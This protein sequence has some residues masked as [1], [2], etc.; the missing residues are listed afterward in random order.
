MKFIDIS[1]KN[2]RCFNDVKI[3]LSTK[4]DD[5]N[6][7]LILAPNGG[8]KTET[9]FSFWW[10]LYGFD[11]RTLK[12]K[13]DAP[14]SL[15]QYK[16]TKLLQSP[17][18]YD[19]TVAVTLRF[20][21]GDYGYALKKEEVFTKKGNGI[22]SKTRVGLMMKDRKK[23]QTLPLITDEDRIYRILT[24]IIPKRILHGIVFDGERMKQL[25]TVDDDAKEAIQGII[26]DITNEE[27]FEMCKTELD[28]L[29]RDNNKE[30][31]KLSSSNRSSNI[32]TIVADIEA[33]DQAIRF[34]QVDM[35]AKIKEK[36]KIEARLLEITAELKK[37]ETAREIEQK[38]D[39]LREKLAY[40]NKHFD[41]YITSFFL[42]L[43]DGY[44]LIADPMFSSVEN[45]LQKKDIPEELT[46]QAVRNILKRDKCICGHDLGEHE[47]ELLTELIKSLPPDNVSSTLLEMT[48]QARNT[49]DDVKRRLSKS[50]KD[51]ETQEREI[52]EIKQVLS[53]ISSQLVGEGFS[54]KAKELENE[55][56]DLRV[57]LR[58]LERQIARDKSTIETKKVEMDSLRKEKASSSKNDSTLQY[59]D[60][61]DQIITKFEKA[62][63]EIDR[64]N[65][66]NALLNINDKLD[67]A[68]S[69]ISE[70]YERGRRIYIVQFDAR[71]KYRL[72]SY[73]AKNLDELYLTN[74]DFIKTLT[75][76]CKNEAEIR[77]ALILKICEPNSTGQSK[78][79]TLAFAK[80]ILDYSNE[81]R[82]KESVE[83]TKNYPFLIDSPFTELSGGNLS[84]SA[85]FIHTFSKQI[86]LLISEKSYD[87]VK[88][89][90]AK[91][92]C[93]I[94]K[95][96]KDPSGRYSF[97]EEGGN[98]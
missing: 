92:V 36:N 35:E 64:L 79:N 63:E 71:N 88:D 50:F 25:S 15:N 60:Q 78:I 72:V 6:I 37:D 90:V 16:Y 2:Y 85:E 95:I 48:R 39:Q 51:I 66:V 80:A 8:G 31:K 10:V 7:N 77:E 68:Y 82:D 3:T 52:G 49:S 62:L 21:D 24:K 44:L 67:R 13:K 45:S 81:E 89:K 43:Y 57:N 23:G 26:K 87:T 28:E 11:F 65:G 54:K 14:Y 86:I 58:D 12:E 1:Y 74:K 98:K 76:Q 70:D 69:Q 83:I 5:K 91:H 42:D 93:C 20:V 53:T 96:K 40:A 27:L 22:T 29:K 97:I 61:K 4:D 41:E 46:V 94:T 34:A 33:A 75:T 55:S 30:V 47:R 32:E 59:L 56:I 38:R 9:L 19:E 18:G 73:Y 17:E 84:Q